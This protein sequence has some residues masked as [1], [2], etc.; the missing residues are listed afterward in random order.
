VSAP[1]PVGN[2]AL[3]EEETLG[4]AYDT[5]LARRLW[6]YVAP[7]RAQVAVTVLMLFPLM[8]FE[9]APAWIV[10][11]GIDR[12]IVPRATG[13]A[14]APSEWP[15]APALV[16]DFAWSVAQSA[17]GA[18]SSALE[19][20]ANIPP[21]AWLALVYFVVTAL[22][23]VV[24]YIDPLVMS[25]TGQ[26]AMRDLRREVFAHIQRLHL[27]FFDT[28]PVG[29]L[30]TRATN[31]VENVAEMFSAGIAAL[32]RDVFKMLGL[33]LALFCID[34][35]LAGFTFLVIP[36]LAVGAFVFRWKVREAFRAVRVRIAR[37]NAYLQEN[38]VGMKVVQ[39]F[40]REAKSF[41]DFD[42]MNADHRDAWLQSIRYDSALFAVVEFASGI[43]IALVIWQ[44][45]GYAEAGT[46]YLFIDWTRRFFLPLRDLSA[47]Y[48]VMQSSMA[49]AERIFA[50]LDTPPAVLD[51]PEAAMPAAPARRGLVEF[52]RVWFSYR[53]DGRPDDWVLR[54]VSFR[55]EPGQ[56]AAF[57]GATGAGKTTIIKLLT[58]LYDVD[59]GSI[60]IDGV[61][62]REW[63]QSEL[64]R[65]VAMVLQDVFLFSG[66]IEQNLSLG[67]AEI[68]R[69]RVQRAASAV[70]ADRF[71]ARLPQGY[72]TEVRERGT[73][74]S[75]GQRQLL[76]FARA[77]A[78]GADVLVLDEATSA[79]DSETEALVQE[80]IHVLMAE[81]TALVIAHRLSTIQDAD[82]IH[83]LHKGELVESGTHEELMG[84][85]GIYQRLYRLQYAEQAA[86]LAAA[87][88]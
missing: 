24:S 49:S 83:V 12:E 47:K 66:S 7:Y 2:Q 20:P 68:D 84:R 45:A 3:F 19:A 54:D 43:T 50:L 55:V 73:N 36:L 15:A 33:A 6:R 65:R 74:L 57:V 25:L 10:E 8:F 30:V 4:K 16:P 11:T 29:R 85:A 26:A 34:A 77:L 81:K 31:D 58:R 72:E 80:G 44:G 27:G 59:R 82:C 1:G 48:S 70:Q 35:R 46:I 21:L 52:D 18:L 87:G 63:P 38:V 17:V 75:A 76:S 13:I 22:S 23:G 37:I 51:P 5:Y 88:A 69:E 56:S 78:Y 62:L 67:R 9:L 60:R 14:L 86:P 28:M 61:D 71:I 40:T 53:K 64:R 42:A 39:L 32:V 79:I 41:R